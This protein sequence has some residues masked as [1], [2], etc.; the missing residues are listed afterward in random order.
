MNS[1]SKISNIAPNTKFPSTNPLT[2]CT[3]NGLERGFTHGGQSDIY[4]QYSKPC[5]LYV[6]EY[7]AQGWDEFCEVSSQNK[8]TQYPVNFNN[9]N[10]NL[11][12]CNNLTHGEGLIRN[13]ASRKYLVKMHNGI[14]KYEPFDPNNPD[15]PMVT[16]WDNDGGNLIP[17]FEVDPKT[18]DKDV[19]MNKILAKPCIAFNI[20]INIY[21]TMKRNNKIN[22]LKN[23]KLGNFYKHNPYFIQKGGI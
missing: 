23:T 10:Q 18:I 2:Y 9:C 19:V 11:V 15:S 3:G 7:C 16:Y 13:T 17:E 6:S 21:N 14:K 8:S 4:G 12:A 1:Y 22:Q 20:L 5:Q